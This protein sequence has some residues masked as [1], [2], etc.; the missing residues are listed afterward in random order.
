MNGRGG[1]LRFYGFCRLH[2]HIERYIPEKIEDAIVTDELF[3]ARW[4][5]E[6]S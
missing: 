1:R 5:V 6:L 3:S 4:P 2:G